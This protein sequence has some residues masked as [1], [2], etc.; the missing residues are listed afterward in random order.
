MCISTHSTLTVVLGLIIIIIIIIIIMSRHILDDLSNEIWHYS[1][2]C[3][4][5]SITRGF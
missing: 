4:I 5:N 2:L 3:L 1:V